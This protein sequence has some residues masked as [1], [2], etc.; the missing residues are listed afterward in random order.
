MCAT[1]FRYAPTRQQKLLLK[2]RSVRN[3]ELSFQARWNYGGHL[4]SRPG[5]GRLRRVRLGR[6]FRVQRQCGRYR[7]PGGFAYGTAK[8]SSAWS[9]AMTFQ[10][11][12][13]KTSAIGAPTFQ[14]GLQALGNNRSRVQCANTQCLTGS[15]ALDDVL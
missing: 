15:V 7:G 2:A 6:A 10:Q 4:E 3:T 12:V 9:R 14:P 5:R 8:R 11:A 1:S 13:A